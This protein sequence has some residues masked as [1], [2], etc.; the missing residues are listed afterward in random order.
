MSSGRLRDPG[1][2]FITGHESGV[3]RALGHEVLPLRRLAN[4]REKVDVVVDSILRYVGRQEDA[5]QHEILAVNARLLAGRDVAHG[6]VGGDLLGKLDPF[7]VEPA[8]RFRLAR[9]TER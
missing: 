8:P 5:A 7:A 6:H 4:L 9:A 1:P 2:E 3:E